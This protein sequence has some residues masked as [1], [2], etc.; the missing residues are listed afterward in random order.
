LLQRN[1][2]NILRALNRCI[3]SNEND[4]LSFAGFLQIFRQLRVP[5]SPDDNHRY[6]EL[7]LTMTIN[8]IFHII[9]ARIRFSKGS[10]GFYGTATALSAANVDGTENDGGSAEGSWKRE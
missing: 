7:L 8:A 2:T 3:V 1:L 4:G 5:R 9:R 6:S 10:R